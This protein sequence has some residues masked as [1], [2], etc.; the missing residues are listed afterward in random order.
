LDKELIDK[1]LSLLTESNKYSIEAFEY[2]EGNFGN[3]WLVLKSDTSLNIRFVRD[4]GF[5]NCSVGLGTEVE[6]KWLN[7]KDIFS[8]LKL[9]PPLLPKDTYEFLV[10]SCKIIL[11]NEGLLNKIKNPDFFEELGEKIYE[12]NKQNFIEKHHLKLKDGYYQK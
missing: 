7:I 12:R 2:S 4:R 8:I 10:Q 11:D 5:M 9:E 1:S 6:D 3:F